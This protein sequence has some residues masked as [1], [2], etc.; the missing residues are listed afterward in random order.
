MIKCITK[1]FLVESHVFILQYCSHALVSGPTWKKPASE[2][3]LY[4]G[5]IMV[6]MMC[7]A[8][9]SGSPHLHAALYLSGPMTFSLLI[10]SSR[11]QRRFS[12]V[13]CRCGRSSPSTPPP[14]S[15]MYWCIRD[16]P[17]DSH[18]CFRD[19]ASYALVDK[20]SGM[21]FSISC[22]ALLYK[23]AGLE[24]VWRLISTVVLCRICQSCILAFLARL[25]VLACRRRPAGAIP[26]RTGR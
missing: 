24:S 1:L 17:A 6:T 19:N 11:L 25:M 8:H 5:H 2:G 3:G 9:C 22:A 13:H 4:R 14:G 10:W 18:S 12:R 23:V 15:Q 21:E 16:G 7:S 20:S 26:A